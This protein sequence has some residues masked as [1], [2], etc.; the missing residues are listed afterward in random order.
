MKK[1]K[2]VFIS[3]SS[4]GIGKGIAKLL[5]ESGYTVIINGRKDLSLNKTFKEFSNLF[6]NK[7]FSINIFVKFFNTN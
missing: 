3:G 4:R 7:I 6:P 5:L 2:V 1:N